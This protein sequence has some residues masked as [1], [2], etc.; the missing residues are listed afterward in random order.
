VVDGALLAVVDVV[1][2][3]PDCDEGFGGR[4][5]FFEN[6]VGVGFVLDDLIF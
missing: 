6:W 4:G 5:Q 3:D 1:D 2:A